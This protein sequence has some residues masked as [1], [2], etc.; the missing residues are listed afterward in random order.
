MSLLAYEKIED[1]KAKGVE[2]EDGAFGENIV[3]SGIELASLPVGTMLK[4]GKARLR[5]T[6]IG[7][8]CHHHCAIYHAVGDCIMPREGIFTEVIEG[9]SLKKGDTIEIDTEKQI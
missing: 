4:A 9:G 6:Q 2:L 1:F 7:K 3:V 5:V 8:K